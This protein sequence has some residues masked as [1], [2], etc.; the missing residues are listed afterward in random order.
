MWSRVNEEENRNQWIYDIRSESLEYVVE[1]FSRMPMTP[2]ELQ[3]S[4][5][6]CILVLCTILLLLIFFP[7][8]IHTIV[9][10]LR[11]TS[12]QAIKRIDVDRSVENDDSHSMRTLCVRCT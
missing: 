4:L 10:F 11:E 3:V 5:V 9:Y 7:L 1:N 6:V 8:Q 12:K 2:F